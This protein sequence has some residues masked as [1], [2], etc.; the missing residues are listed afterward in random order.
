MKNSHNTNPF[1]Q[2]IMAETHAHV[3]RERERERER[4]LSAK[5]YL[6]P[7]F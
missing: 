4:G 7:K 6:I 1:F 5:S 3:E 2:T